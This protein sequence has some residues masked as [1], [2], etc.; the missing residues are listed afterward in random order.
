MADLKEG[1]HIDRYQILGL[2]GKGGMGAVYKA[3]DPEL[4]RSIAIKM[5]TVACCEGET[6]SKPQARLMREAQALAKLSHPNVVSIFD[7]G[8]YQQSV[9]IAMEYVK[10]RTL[11]EWIGK[12]KPTQKQIIKVF[13][14]AG[15]GLHAAHC[16]GIVHR[17]F[18][19]ENVVVGDKGQVKVLD[20]GLARAAANE[21]TAFSHDKP[22]S[23][24][25]PSSGEK[26]LSTPLTKVGATVGT[27][28]YMAPEHFLREKLD[29]KTDQFSFC[30]TLFEALYGTRPF[31]GDTLL[32]FEENLTFG[33]IVVP[34]TAHVPKW[35]EDIILKGLSSSQNDRYGSML[36]LLEALSVDPYLV[37]AQKQKRMLLWL[38]STLSAAF[39]MFVGHTFFSKSD[40][41]CTGAER[42]LAGIWND[43]IRDKMQQ[44]FVDSQLSY[45]HDSYSRVANRFDAYL[46]RW[47]DEYTENCRATRVRGEQSEKTMDLKRGCLNNH[48]QN[49]NALINVLSQADKKVVG[50]AIQ[51]V[52]SLS[53]FTNCNDTEA[54]Q[55]AVRPIKDEQTKI[56]VAAIRK[57]LAHV[58]AFLNT[59]KYQEGLELA[60]KLENEA[61]D[62]DYKPV[63]AEVQLNLGHLLDRIG[64]Y[65]QAE[66]ALNDAARKAGKCEDGLL[67][68]KALALLVWVVGYSQARYEV[69]LSI[70]R[71]AEIMLDVAKGDDKLRSELYNNI[72][73]VF[74]SKGDY[75]K[76][77]K[78]FLRELQIQEKSIGTKD[79]RLAVTLNNLGVVLINKGDYDRSLDYYRRSLKI[80]QAALGSDHPETVHPL[81]NLGVVFMAKG[82]HEK[83]L[84]NYQKSLSIRQKALGHDH[85]LV[86]VTLNNLGEVHLKNKDFDNAL[87]YHLQ[88]LAIRQK[89]LGP[90]HPN[91]VDSLNGIGAVFLEKQ[92]PEK[93]LEPLESAVT[94][95]DKKTCD[96]S[97]QGNVLFGLARA[98]VSTGGDNERAVKLVKQA[99]AIFGKTPMVSKKEI[100]ELDVWLKNH[101]KG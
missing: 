90:E 98:L 24:R 42:S 17:D 13:S 68:A 20:F 47:K 62:I 16:E 27:T 45:A 91:L 85:P 51:A 84:T 89:V 88:A 39:F 63:Q 31:P 5:L 59:G 35:I 34:E 58:E 76:A 75:D 71:D 9:Y 74:G 92:I 32:D 18:K 54:L 65:K 22:N 4:D 25:E 87:S 26:L 81:N 80:W 43:Q 69:G 73:V 37:K 23:I 96:Q 70:A 86:A 33:R 60:H 100:E 99:R 83:A 49:A 61:E 8:T 40:E 50:K 52:S 95:C 38:A 15:K 36:E 94:I 78:Y 77:L 14:K 67:A 97:L 66:T 21:E 93:A 41:L 1:T 12:T 2:L 101:G 30:V 6:A 19:P 46:K 82:M 29:E 79:H 28:L 55:S 48:L 7:V 57:K 64:E 11:R 53:G 10:G 56:K 72:G 44:A 3:Y